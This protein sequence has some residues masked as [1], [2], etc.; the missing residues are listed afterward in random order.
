[1]VGYVVSEHGLIK[2]ASGTVIG[3]AGSLRMNQPHG[4][5]WRRISFNRRFADPIVIAQ[6]ATYAGKQPCHTRLRRVTREDFE[7]QIEEWDY[8]DRYHTTETINY[9]VI[10][11]GRYTLEG[12]QVIQAGRR[13][14]N[15]LWKAVSFDSFG[16]PPLLF[17]HAQTY[18][19]RAA[20]VTRQRNITK[21]GGEVRLQ[22]E[23][24][25]DDK[26]KQEEVGFIAIQ[27]S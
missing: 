26:H 21:D 13:V 5:R 8:L 20:V 25:N 6:I 7:V 15:H 27:P 11:Q 10:E 1:M 22:E 2:D 18:E 23:E 17:S 14:I 9:L 3:M 12:N 24:A 4:G 19:G 16:E